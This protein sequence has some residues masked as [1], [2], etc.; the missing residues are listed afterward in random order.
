MKKR[1]II[2]LAIIIGIFAVIQF[3]PIEKP[4]F[5]SENPDDLIVNNDLPSDISAILK[6]AC[7]DCHSNETNYP[8]YAHVF[9]VK[10]LVY[11]DVKEGRE[12]LNF[13]NWES[14]KK[15]DKATILDEISSEVLDGE[16]P[17]KIYIQMHS[18]AK[19]SDDQRNNLASWADDFAESLFE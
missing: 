14:Q 3:I 9:P 8:W 6:N 1:T 7:Y 11:N 4:G 17:M 16:M 10:M 13:S 18:G 15:L 2:I 12:K 5:V 19:L